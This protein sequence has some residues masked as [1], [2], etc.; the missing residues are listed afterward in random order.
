[1]KKVRGKRNSFQGHFQS[2]FSKKCIFPIE[3]I[4]QKLWEKYDFYKKRV[5]LCTGKLF[6]FGILINFELKLLIEDTGY[7][8]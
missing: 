7:R 6:L 5:K 1:V 8:L 3:E 2:D 4:Y